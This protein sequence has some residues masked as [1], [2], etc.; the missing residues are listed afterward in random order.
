MNLSSIPTWFHTVLQ[1]LHC[2]QKRGISKSF[3]WIIHQKFGE[4]DGFVSLFV[5]LFTISRAEL[6]ELM[7]RKKKQFSAITQAFIHCSMLLIV[8]VEQCATSAPR[9]PDIYLS[10]KDRTA[11]S[12][13]EPNYSSHKV[14]IVILSLK[15]KRDI[16]IYHDF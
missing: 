5:F 9:C 6:L 10:H 11:A 1:S 13:W 16:H 7:K 2:H 3:W 14:A 15:F 4:V 8:D 12:N